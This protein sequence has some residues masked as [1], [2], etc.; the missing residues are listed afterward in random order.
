MIEMEGLGTFEDQISALED[1][2][3]N[4]RDVTA[5]LST[6]LDKANSALSG[7]SSGVHSLSTG[8]GRNLSRAFESVVFDGM[9]LSEALTRVG[10]SM[11]NSAFSAAVK[12]V[13]NQFGNLV[14]S[15]IQNLVSSAMPFAGG[16]VAQGGRVTPFADGGIVGRPTMFPTRGGVG[17]M[18]EAGAE[19][20]LPL[21]RGSN[22]K[23][24]V[25]AEGAARPVNVVFNI[26]TP[27]VVGFQRSQSQIAAQMSRALGRGER[28]R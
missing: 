3:A 28:N 7:A 17:L 1:A 9:K 20:I 22:G 13:S 25:R 24:G 23:L 27:D 6:E 18:G 11:V 26:T 15:G 5:G 16:G 19:A 12:P 4:A 2:M 10:R 8:L 14:S 21:G